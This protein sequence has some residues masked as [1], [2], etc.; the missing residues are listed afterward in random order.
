MSNVPNVCSIL[1]IQK[2]FF[3]FRTHSA[4][5]SG[6][7]FGSLHKQK[8][9]NLKIKLLRVCNVQAFKMFHVVFFAL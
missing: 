2:S 5:S 6:D 7:R 4:G 1:L 9:H 3:C 8:V